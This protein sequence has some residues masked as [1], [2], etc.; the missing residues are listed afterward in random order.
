MTCFPRI[1]SLSGSRHSR[2][3]PAYI[4]ECDEGTP[5]VTRGMIRL[6]LPTH[7]TVEDE[8]LRILVRFDSLDGFSRCDGVDLGIWHRH[9]GRFREF[10]YRKELVS[11]EQGRERC[12]SDGERLTDEGGRDRQCRS[13]YSRGALGV[14]D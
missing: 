3:E 13:L 6:G 8:I 11:E 9:D 1:F 4:G 5:L 7:T 14:A 10:E 12:G 2:A